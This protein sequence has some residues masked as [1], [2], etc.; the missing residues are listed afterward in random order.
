M[1]KHSTPKPQA[2]GREGGSYK[3][4]GATYGK[5]WFDLIQR[6]KQPTR[7]ITLNPNIVQLVRIFWTL[8]L[9]VQRKILFKAWVSHCVKECDVRG[10]GV[11]LVRYYE[12][13]GRW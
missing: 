2:Q 13:Q 8:G 6:R 4:G 5:Y 11:L 12:L 10:Q 9:E 7:I 3:S 1:V